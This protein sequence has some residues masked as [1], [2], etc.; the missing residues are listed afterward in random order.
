MQSPQ[1]KTRARGSVWDH[2]TLLVGVHA[3]CF[4][5][6]FYIFKD[7]E[8]GEEREALEDDGDVGLGGGDGFAM[9]EDLACGWDGEAG[10]HAKEG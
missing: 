8:P 1:G 6:C 5:G 2:A 9:P 3:T 7:G 10:Q 4:Q